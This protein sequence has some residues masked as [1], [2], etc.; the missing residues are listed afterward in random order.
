M[1]E[2]PFLSKEIIEGKANQLLQT[3]RAAG[4]IEYKPPIDVESIIENYLKLGLE[5]VNFDDISIFGGL[6][7]KNRIIKVNAAFD[8]YDHRKFQGLYHFTLAHEI[9]HQILHVPLLNVKDAILCRSSHAYKRIE[10]QADF[11]AASLLMPRKLVFNTFTE[12]FGNLRPY[13]ADSIL[14]KA[15][16][17]PKFK[18]IVEAKKCSFSPMAIMEVVFE[19]LARIFSVSPRA[20]VIRLKELGLLVLEG[21]LMEE[22]EHSFVLSV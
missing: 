19:K 13:H 2:A 14:I 7:V 15:S 5:I 12:M 20:M 4:K 16:L 18:K 8:P 17:D 1:I 6:D 9:G 22:F 11:F 21:K 3:A 10:W